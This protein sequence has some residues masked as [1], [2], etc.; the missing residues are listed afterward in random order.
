MKVY[1]GTTAAAARATRSPAAG[2]WPSLHQHHTATG[3]GRRS[4]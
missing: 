1:L 4:R 2:V 3:I